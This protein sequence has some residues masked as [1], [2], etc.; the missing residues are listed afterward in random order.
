MPYNPQNPLIVQSDR[1]LLLEVDNPAYEAARDELARF[2]ELEK[3]P[4]H[5][6]TYRVTPLSLWNAASAG[7]TVEEV[8]STLE[9]Y[10]KFDLPANVLTDIRDYISRFGRLKLVRSE[11]GDLLLQSEDP[12]LIAEV[13]HHK[14]M[15]AYV[16]DRPDRNTLLID[17]RM[18]GH[19]KQA[20]VQFGYPAEDLAG[21]TDGDHLPIAL[22]ESTLEGVPFSV[23]P[24]QQDAIGAFWAG[25]TVHGGSGVVVLPCGA[26]KTVVGMGVMAQAQTHTLIL[27]PSTTAVRQWISELLDKTSLSAQQVGE[28]TGDRKEVRPVTVTTYQMLT[29]RPSVSAVN[30]ETGEIG[31]FPHFELFTKYNWGLIIYDEVHLLPAPVF[32][33]TAEIQARR[34]LGLTATLVREDGHET[35]VFSLIGPKK[36]DVPWKD[37][38]R[39]GW[40]ATAECTELRLPLTPEERMAYM[41]ADDSRVKYRIAAENPLKMDVLSA[42]LERHRDDCVLVIGQYLGQ[43]E[44][45]AREFH[46]PLVTGKTPNSERDQ[47]YADFR[48]G[49]LKLLVVSKVANFAIDLPDA[50]VAI[51]VSGTFGSRQEEAQ[52]LG[53]ILRPK[54]DGSVANFYTLV[55]HDTKDQDFSTNRQLFLT[56]QGYRYNIVDAASILPDLPARLAHMQADFDRK[57]LSGEFDIEAL[58]ARRGLDD[59]DEAS[60]DG[61]G[62]GRG[63]GRAGRKDAQSGAE[64]P[65]RQGQKARARHTEKPAGP[66]QQQAQAHPPEIEAAMAVGAEDR[67]SVTRRRGRPPAQQSGRDRLRLIK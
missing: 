35:D 3:S 57:K 42:L 16:L 26:G 45:I 39:Q 66:P 33:I 50:N 34:R 37:L 5:I 13:A 19:V 27:T 8:L 20:L 10:S 1:S 65:Q 51:Q 28:Y 55:T 48:A 32:R 11:A 2:A 15:R 44:R 30:E 14:L 38:E 36:Y 62:R 41:L 29:Y 22:R 24:Y 40:I 17:P 61:K 56:E 25:G 31:E 46:A 18:R 64:E 63:R 23:R 7:I 6:H 60:S 9:R 52:R 43:L 12:M 67:Q 58:L 47:L 21:Y 54:K 49:R 59:Q 53:R 4:E